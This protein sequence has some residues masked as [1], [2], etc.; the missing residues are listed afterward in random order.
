MRV[1]QERLCETHTH[2]FCLA[3]AMF[4]TCMATGGALVAQT[5]TE[6]EKQREQWAARG[7]I[8]RAMD[9]RLGRSG[10]L[11]ACASRQRSVEKL[12]GIQGLTAQLR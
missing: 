4:A 9:V 7:D 5:R 8:F 11:V 3:L 2:G 10:C 6:R 1:N 12:S